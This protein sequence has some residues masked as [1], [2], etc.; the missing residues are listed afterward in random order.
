MS[1]GTPIRLMG[2]RDAGADVDMV[3]AME[4]KMGEVK[5]EAIYSR[6]EFFYS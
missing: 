4:H 3:L 2:A 1:V 5:A 6:T